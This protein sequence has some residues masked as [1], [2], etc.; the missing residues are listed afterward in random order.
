MTAGGVEPAHGPDDL[1]AAR[2]VPGPA[3]GPIGPARCLA[4]LRGLTSPDPRQRWEAADA[5]AALRDLGGLDADEGRALAR[6]LSWAA[7]V[8]TG[9]YSP[10]PGQRWSIRE[11]LLISL[12]QLAADG[13]APA[14]ALGSV[15]AAVPRAVVAAE[16]EATYAQLVE[17]RS[18]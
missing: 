12:V 11:G 8:E 5:P 9:W 10:E 15:V 17:A 18:W 4:L 14:D 2:S 6:V 7:A 13:W 1:R 16:E 3:A